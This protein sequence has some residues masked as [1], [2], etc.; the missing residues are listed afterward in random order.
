M[1]DFRHT[2]SFSRPTWADLFAKSEIRLLLEVVWLDVYECSVR[3]AAGSSWTPKDWS[4]IYRSG[5]QVYGA[6][7]PAWRVEGLLSEIDRPTDRR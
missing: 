2:C 4:C 5:C 6:R 3:A 1:S 7:N